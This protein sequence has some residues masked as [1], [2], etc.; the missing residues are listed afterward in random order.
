MSTGFILL[1]GVLIGFSLTIA[2]F[3]LARTWPGF[4]P[5]E[6]DT[7]LRM[8]RY[9]DSLRAEWRLRP[10]WKAVRY[11]GF[12][13]LVWLLA[14]VIIGLLPED[15]REQPFFRSLLMP[16]LTYGPVLVLFFYDQVRKNKQ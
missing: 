11:P 5:S 14:G 3:T 12:T 16:L 7:K 1:G 10:A 6:P 9:V 13:G 15:V 4:E 8:A 2:L